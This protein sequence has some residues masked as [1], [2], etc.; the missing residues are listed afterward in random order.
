MNTICI[1]AGWMGM[2][3]VLAAAQGVG[4]APEAGGF[5]MESRLPFGCCFVEGEP[6]A[7]SYAVHFGGDGA[8]AFELRAALTDDRGVELGSFTQSARLRGGELFAIDPSRAVDGAFG[9]G[10]LRPVRL[11]SPRSTPLP[12]MRGARS[13]EGG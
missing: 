11:C 7:L 6:M 10:V 5:E 13:P 2:A 8:R 9:A 12:C 3:L 1:H 4:A